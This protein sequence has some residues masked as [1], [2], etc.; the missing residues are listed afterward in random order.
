MPPRRIAVVR[1]ASA[2][3]SALL[4]GACATPPDLRARP[5]VAVLE[6][7]T[8]AARLASCLADAYAADPFR[9]EV[10]PTGRGARITAYGTPG[11]LAP[12]R[13]RP[14]FEIEIADT[15][16]GTADVVLRAAPTL[17]GPEAEVARLR[18]RVDACADA[19]FGGTFRSI[20]GAPRGASA[21][22]SAHWA[23]GIS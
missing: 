14:R 19:A 12:W 6:V 7:R 9:L 22:C 18:R 17:L 13:R 5:P 8:S 4:L 20:A 21:S 3:L 10:D 15:G 2:A 11:R 16:P 1:T 23:G